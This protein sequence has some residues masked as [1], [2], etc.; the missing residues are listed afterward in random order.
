[1]NNQIMRQAALIV[2]AALR[3]DDTTVGH[4]L[5]NQPP[6]Q[7]AEIAVASVTALAEIL[8]QHIPAEAIRAGVSE[9][10]RLAHNAATGRTLS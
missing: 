2:S 7:L 1:M 3:D 4:L 6:D 10:Q 9:A 5:R 8:H